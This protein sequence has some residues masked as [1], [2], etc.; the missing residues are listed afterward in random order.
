MK[1]IDAISAVI[2]GVMTLAFAAG[3]VYVYYIDEALFRPVVG[4]LCTLILF[5]PRLIYAKTFLK[6]QLSTRGLVFLESAW[7][8]I[9]ALNALG[10]LSFYTTTQYYDMVLH[11]VD[12]LIGACVLAVVV[13]AWEKHDGDYSQSHVLYISLAAT[14]MLIFLWEA[15]EYYGDV[16]F[17]TKMFGQDGEQYDTLYDIIAGIAALVVATPLIKRYTHFF[18]K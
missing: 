4:L 10:S 7:W 9:L 2:T 1:K 17:G 15:Y 3:T 11:F 18:L 5:A 8:L 13:T 12:P 16:W 14:F 6:E